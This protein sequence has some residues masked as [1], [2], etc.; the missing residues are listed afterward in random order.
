MNVCDVCKQPF[1]DGISCVWK[2]GSEVAREDLGSSGGF[3]GLDQG[4]SGRRR[5]GT[6]FEK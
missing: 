6:S 2:A 1:E 4:V 3:S 5:A